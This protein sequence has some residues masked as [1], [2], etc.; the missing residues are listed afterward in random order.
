MRFK[1]GGIVGRDESQGMDPV[2]RWIIAV[3]GILSVLLLGLGVYAG[4]QTR[5]HNLKCLDVCRKAGYSSD[6]GGGS[7]WRTATCACT[8]LVN[9]SGQKVTP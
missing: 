8:N 3:L 1:V 7:N 5:A 6:Q 4:L 9:Y 2:W